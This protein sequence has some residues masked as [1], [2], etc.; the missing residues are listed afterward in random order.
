MLGLLWNLIFY[1]RKVGLLIKNNKKNA[2]VILKSWP[3][4]TQFYFAYQILFTINLLLIASLNNDQNNA[5]YSLFPET[6]KSRDY[7]FNSKLE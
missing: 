4:L 7:D 1:N 6:L 3:E 2:S 5:N